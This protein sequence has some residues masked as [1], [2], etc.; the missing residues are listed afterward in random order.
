MSSMHL[1]GMEWKRFKLPQQETNGLQPSYWRSLRE[2]GP[3][4]S[5][6]ISIHWKTVSIRPRRSRIKIRQV[7]GPM[8]KI[9]GYYLFFVT[10][11]GRTPREIGSVHLNMDSERI[12]RPAFSGTAWTA[13]PVFSGISERTTII[14]IFLAWKIPCTLVQGA[15]KCLR[16]VDCPIAAM[17]Y[18]FP[19]DIPVL[20]AFLLI[21]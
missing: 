16:P 18:W 14:N 7:S 8:K 3:Q 11:Q 10:R 21:L 5:Q 17:N 2:P 6:L 15:S 12:P 20:V 19:A 13:C 4:N 9:K 1:A